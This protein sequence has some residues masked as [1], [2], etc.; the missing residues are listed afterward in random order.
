MDIELGFLF[1]DGLVVDIVIIGHQLVDGS[2]WCQFNDTVGHGI[3]EL[4]VVGS[5]QDVAL[6]VDQIIVECLY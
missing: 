4:M 6:E 1:L 3:D 2:L 5:E